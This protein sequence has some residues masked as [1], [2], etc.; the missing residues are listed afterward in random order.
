M[1]LF[2]LSKPVPLVDRLRAVVAMS[3]GLMLRM[4][5]VPAS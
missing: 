4:V 1:R 2:D 3:M 5:V